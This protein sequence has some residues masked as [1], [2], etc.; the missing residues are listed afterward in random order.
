MGGFWQ[1][2]AARQMVYGLV[3]LLVIGAAMIVLLVVHVS[4]VAAPVNAAT[5]HTRATVVASQLGADHQEIDL[6]WTDNR[7]VQH[8]SRLHF[9]G[10]GKIA[11]GTGVDLRYDPDDTSRVFVTGDDTSVRLRD[12]VTDILTLFVV[13]LVALLTTVIRIGRRR[14]A[15]RRAPVDRQMSVAH[16]RR[17]LT[18][19]TWLTETDGGQT[20]WLPV[21]WDPALDRLDPDRRCPVHGAATARGLWIAE[22]DGTPVWPAGRRRIR[23]PRGEV[24]HMST[25]R[26]EGPRQIS[27]RRHLRGDL[28]VTFAAPLL[29][30][31]WAYV[32]N[33]GA[34]GFWTSTVVLAGVLFWIPSVYA[35]DP[36]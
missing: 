30:L 15:E 25:P 1:R 12:L 13:V 26:P 19:R 9:P 35:S 11:A 33:S 14:A 5:A 16:S 27:L 17:G 29:G 31:L 22:I 20:W 34:N 8:T 36:T 3:P 18:T 7:S 6:S 4:A 23:A 21:Y 10:S 28:A 24:T 32:D 2:R